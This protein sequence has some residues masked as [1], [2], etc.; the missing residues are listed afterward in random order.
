MKGTAAGTR[1]G[2]ETY[3]QPPTT[4]PPGA[5]KQNTATGE[6]PATAGAATARAATAAPASFL[7]PQIGSRRASLETPASGMTRGALEGLSSQARHG[8]SD[9]D[10][11]RTWP[12]EGKR[13][14]NAI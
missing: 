2:L 11:A 10:Q 1:M 13:R 8:S 5:R 14:F 7:G 6:A 3:R 12:V 4:A 9:S